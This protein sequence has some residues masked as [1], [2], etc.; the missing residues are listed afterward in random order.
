M[1]DPNS[2]S[3]EDIAAR[4]DSLL[5]GTD[6]P[7][8]PLAMNHV[9]LAMFALLAQS[10]A[11]TEVFEQHEPS[12]PA[13]MK[14]RLHNAVLFARNTLDALGEAQAWADEAKRAYLKGVAESN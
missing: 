14:Q 7:G 8:G 4:I 5:S 9:Q 12:L 13:E 2:L 6:P 3:Q 11:I 10:T 1:T